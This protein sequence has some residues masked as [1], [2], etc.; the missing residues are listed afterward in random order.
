MVAEINNVCEGRKKRMNMWDIL[1][2][3]KTKNSAAIKNAFTKLRGVVP[4]N[5][6]KR[7]SAAYEF[8]L[9][10]A[11]VK[12]SAD[13]LKEEILLEMAFAR[14]WKEIEENSSPGSNGAGEQIDG[15]ITSYIIEARPR[16]T[17][18][19]DD[20][21]GLMDKAY[22]NFFSRRELVSWEILI[23]QNAFWN[24][25][26]KELEPV[27]QDFLLLHRNLP[28]DVWKLFDKE[29]HWSDRIDE[30]KESYL[31]F[32]RCVLIETCPLWSLDFSFINR[33]AVYDYENYIKFR[34]LTREAA[35]ENDLDG[36]RKYFDKAIDIYTNDPGLYEIVAVFYSSQQAF[37]K[38]GE[39]G[40][41]FLHALNKLIKI[42]YD[43]VK[44]LRER[45]EYFKRCE[46][47]E[48]SRD[49]YEQAMKL[50]PEDL[51][52]PYEIADTYILQNESGKAKNYL[53]YIKKIYQ[54][55]QSSL[56]KQMSTT[57]DRDK[58]SET[59]NA[60]DFV[61]GAVFEQLK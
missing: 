34:R 4:A 41:E 1:G 45:G 60:N 31:P 14:Q 20:Y 46:Y 56:E 21:L 59:I 15:R 10:Q 26:K 12:D 50:S 29:Y 44:Y 18:L 19:Y 16:G 3:E 6:S 30:L 42:H 27:I 54:K 17:T 8:A 49:D 7:L 57:K 13:S 48:E 22:F 39:F 5:E 23:Q 33:D 51:R 9:R 53:K 52:L 35:L 55:T 32:A 24:S 40:P 2:I 28:S 47:F 61:L 58:V 38:Y 37:N 11:K 36:V 43:D 25:H